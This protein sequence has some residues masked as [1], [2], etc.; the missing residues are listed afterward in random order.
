[1]SQRLLEVIQRVV[2]ETIAQQRTA[3]LGV[4]TTIFPHEAEDDANNYEADVRLKYEDLELRRVPVAVP[5]MGVAVPPK[6]GD[7]VLVHFVNGDLNQPVIGGRFYHADER[8]PLHRA[9][10]IL[11]EQR[12]SDG[13]LNH[14]RFTPDGSIYI[15][16]D[17]T[18]PE[19]NSEAKAGIK[20]DP[21]GN[22]EITAG[23]KIVITLTNDDTIAIKADGQPIKIECDT[24]SVKGNVKI[25][26]TLDVTK[27]TTLEAKL[28]VSGDT[29]VDTQVVVGQGPRTTITGGA[30]QGG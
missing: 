30:I 4:V 22:I 8:P 16:R 23:Q 25:D 13:T 29:T 14:L 21:E 10:D 1:M 27:D 15:Q 7:L 12:V 9:E 20:I 2:Q 17:V 18:K 11:F 5:H 6:A 28:G 26:G 19:D 24:M 3:M